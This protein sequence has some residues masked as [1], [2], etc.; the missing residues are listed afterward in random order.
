MSQSGKSGPV[1]PDG[2]ASP[3]EPVRHSSLEELVARV[4]ENFARVEQ[5]RAR[6]DPALWARAFG[7]GA[8]KGAGIRNAQTGL[9][10]GDA[11]GEP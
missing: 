2:E 1:D 4:P 7:P 6:V 5:L 9:R 11:T 8:W 10:P 3:R